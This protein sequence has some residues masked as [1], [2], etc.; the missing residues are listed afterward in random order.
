[1]TGAFVMRSASSRPVSRSY[2][3]DRIRRTGRYDSELVQFS[4]DHA[5]AG[6]VQTGTGQDSAPLG[7][8]ADRYLGVGAAPESQ[9]AETRARLGKAL[10]ELLQ[11][12]EQPAGGQLRHRI[13]TEV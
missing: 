13:T 6:A 12:Q 1:M 4:L 9:S 5:A 8:V 2:Q 10:R 11:F 3:P 7:E